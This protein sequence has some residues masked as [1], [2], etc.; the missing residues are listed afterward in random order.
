MKA[1]ETVK[2]APKSEAPAT[3]QGKI[4]KALDTIEAQSLTST[5][6]A[7]MDELRVVLKIPAE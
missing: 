2:P 6:Q 5:Q 4:A 1:T 7:A 3:D